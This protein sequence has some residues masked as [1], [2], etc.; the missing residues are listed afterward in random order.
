M[1]RKTLA[2]I[3]EPARGGCPKGRSLASI[4]FKRPFVLKAAI[5]LLVDEIEQPRGSSRVCECAVVIFELDVVDLAEI[6]KAVG[7]MARE[8]PAHARAST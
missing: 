8:T 2:K 3:E 5:A 6:A 7:F 1:S 4:I